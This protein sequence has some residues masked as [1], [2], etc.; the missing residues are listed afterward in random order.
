MGARPGSASKV[1]IGICKFTPLANGRSSDSAWNLR[2]DPEVFDQE[3]KEDSMPSRRERLVGDLRVGVQRPIN[4]P[5]TCI[6]PTH[7]E[8]QDIRE[9]GALPCPPRRT[10]ILKA[11]EVHA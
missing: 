10:G 3:P 1:F 2:A 6:M 9:T 11:G 5:S 7:L 4:H 8:P